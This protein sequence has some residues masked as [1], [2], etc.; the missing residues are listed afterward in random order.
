MMTPSYLLT[1]VFV[2]VLAG[3]PHLAAPHQHVASE[4][5]CDAKDWI[6]RAEEVESLLADADIVSVED[7]GMGVTLPKRV[8]MQAA[9]ATLGGAFKD[10][11]RGRQGGFWESYQAEVA[12]YALDR[13]LGLD[14]VPPTIVRRVEKNRGSLQYW[15]NDCKLY[16]DV[17]SRTPGTPQ[18]SNQLSRMKMFDILINNA[19][20]NAQNF[21]VDP[22]FHI[23]LIDHSRAFTTSKSMMRDEKKLPSQYDRALVERLEHIERPALD[24]IMDGLLLGNQVEAIVRRRDFILEHVQQLVTEKGADKVFF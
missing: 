21:L 16:R 4:T 15:V 7:I 10:I 9:E 24:E 19:D 13:M 23:V 18:W 3:S 6:G 20:R 12:A 17:Q 14:M 1:L 11:K 2:I 8:R 22:H 5:S